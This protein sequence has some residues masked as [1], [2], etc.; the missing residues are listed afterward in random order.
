MVSNQGSRSKK[1]PS[2]KRFQPPKLGKKRAVGAD[3]KDLRREGFLD[4]ARFLLLEKGLEAISMQE[5]AEISKI[6]KGTLYLYFKSKE[7]LLLALL[8]REFHTWMIDF[9]EWSRARSEIEVGDFSHWIVSSLSDRTALLILM[10]HSESIL[11]KN[12]GL[13][14]LVVFKRGL[15]DDLRSVSRDMAQRWAKDEEKIF[16]GLLALHALIVGLYFKSFPI[17]VVKEALKRPDL[18]CLKVDFTQ[19]LA[20]MIEALFLRL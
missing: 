9:Q 4:A 17:P 12:I 13:E 15:L 7:E 18:Q 6:A 2:G 10:A 1:P 11:E 8:G 16:R 14:E 20:W 19:T 5:I 3:L